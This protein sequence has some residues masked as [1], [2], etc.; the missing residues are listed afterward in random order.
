MLSERKSESARKRQRASIGVLLSTRR[1][2]WI[3]VLAVAAVAALTVGAPATAASA[4]DAQAASQA[5]AGQASFPPRANSI[6]AYNDGSGAQPGQW[7]DTINAYNATATPGNTL[8]EVFSYATDM[9]TYCPGGVTA[10]CTLDDLYSYYDP[11]ATSTVTGYKSTQAYA[12]KLKPVDDGNGAQPVIISP[13]IDGR[14]DAGGYLTSFNDLTETLARGYADKVAAQVCAD[15]KIDGIQF[16]LEP[17]DVSTK[18]GQYYFYL[19]IAKD[20]AGQNAGD[21]S[22]DPLGCVDSGHPQG[23]FF[24]VF[25]FAKS[26]QPGTLSAS[27]VRDMFTSYGNGMF[28]DSLYDM[29]DNPAGSLNDVPTYTA[30]VQQE[31]K[32]TKTW[33]DALGIPYGYGIPASATAHEFTTCTGP[34][35]KPGADGSTGNPMLDYTKAAVNAMHDNNVVG[36]PLFRG[37][38]IWDLGDHV[39]WNDDTF[40]TVPASAEILAYLSH[41][42]TTPDADQPGAG[43]SD[44]SGS[45]SPSP[46]GSTAVSDSAA[47]DGTMLAESGSNADTALWAGLVILL[48]GAATLAV[49]RIRFARARR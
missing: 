48:L 4:D 41:N 15:T 32:N 23:R 40:G 46:S 12:T 9:E 25:T 28:I 42:L 49:G 31:A 18:N 20:F 47:D 29:G 10:D 2:G 16:D 34:D 24:S 27:N 19:Q 17:F 35:C 26:I 33:A 21:P 8:S 44:G 5:V 22:S 1:G 38:S 13:V 39:V 7:A 43:G 30:L 45:D 11:A 36:D 3:G 6:W 14:T 37:A